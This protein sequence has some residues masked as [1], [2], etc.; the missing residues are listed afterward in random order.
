M[1]MPDAVHAMLRLAHARQG[2]LSTRVYNI[3]A[4]S[5]SAGQLRDEALRLFPDAQISFEPN[6]VRQAIVDSWPA[7]TDDSLARRD[8]GLAPRHGFPQAVTDYLAPALRMRYT[9]G[10]RA[11]G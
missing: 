6:P 4:F 2:D 3:R 8:W 9:E 5:V 10:T 11:D 7:D 1:T